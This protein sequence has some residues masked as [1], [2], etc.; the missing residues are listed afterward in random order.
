M[1]TASPLARSLS[2]SRCRRRNERL[3]ARAREHQ[4]RGRGSARTRRARARPPATSR[5][6]PRCAARVVEHKITDA[7][8]APA[9]DLLVHVF[10]SFVAPIAPLRPSARFPRGHL[11]VLS[12]PDLTRQH[13]L[14]PNARLEAEQD[15]AHARPQIAPAARG[16][17]IAGHRSRAR[18]GSRRCARRSA[19]ARADADGVRLMTI[20]WPT[21]STRRA[22]ATALGRG[23]GG[24]PAGPRTPGPSCKSARRGRP[25]RSTT[26]T[27]CGA[28][29]LAEHPRRSLRERARLRARS[30]GLADAVVVRAP[31][32][33]RA[34]AALE[35]RLASSGDIDVPVA[36]SNAPIGT[37]GDCS[38]LTRHLAFIRKRAA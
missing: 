15:S 21:S 27:Q 12:L 34:R 36:V 20:G 26:A 28:Q 2:N 38:G 8:L 35:H 3:V 37:V 13:K 5:A 14:A 10:F 16:S 18:A 32:R 23:R 33:R 11:I 19:A 30:A 22:R 4:R 1:P 31:A 9:D 25:R 7:I 6:R 17:P 29:P 24:A